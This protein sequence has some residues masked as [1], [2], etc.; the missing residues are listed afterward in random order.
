MDIKVQ[1]F[2]KANL[3]EYK[4]VIIGAG[5][6]VFNNTKIDFKENE[7]VIFKGFISDEELKVLYAK[8]TLFIYVSLYE[9]FGIPP[10]EAMKMNTATVVS[11]IASLPEVCKDASYFVDP[12]NT[13]DIAN[14]L[15]ELTFD[16]KKRVDL[17]KKGKVLCEKYSWYDSSKKVINIIRNL[18]Y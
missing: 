2:E 12:Y 8:A 5:N 7:N 6:K 1:A 18:K 11:N 13:E 4:L 16:E 15:R 17:V 9:G 14:A 3:S 10:L